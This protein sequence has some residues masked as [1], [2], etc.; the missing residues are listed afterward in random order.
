M[1]YNTKDNSILSL[2]FLSDFIRDRPWAII[3]GLV[4]IVLA[5]LALNSSINFSLA[6]LDHNLIQFSLSAFSM[7]LSLSIGMYLILNDYKRSWGASFLIYSLTFLGLSLEALGFTIAD[8]NE[9]L[10]IL[11]WRSPMIL[12]IAITW[13]ASINLYT[14]KR[15]YIVLS[16]L[17]IAIISLSWFV[18]GLGLLNNIELVMEVFLYA[19]FIPI[20]L[21]SSF[22]WYKFNQEIHFTSTSLLAIGYL[23]IGIIY[24]QWIPW[25][26]LNPIPGYYIFYTILILG[27]ILI[28][29][30]YIKLTK[31]NRNYL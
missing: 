28:F 2:D 25:Q 16:S 3:F 7:G 23:L 10:S 24:S 15:N 8:M 11:L 29:R 30:G 13:Y 17:L 6:N 26:I 27:F 21:I 5:F 18:I 9:P 14:D 20:I 12:F 19:I 1:K 31:E 4:Y 22:I